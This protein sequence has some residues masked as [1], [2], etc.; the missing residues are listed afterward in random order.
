MCDSSWSKSLLMLVKVTN[1]PTRFF[2]NTFN[3][4]ICRHF[5]FS[6]SLGGVEGDKINDFSLLLLPTRLTN[7]FYFPKNLANKYK[8]KKTIQYCWK[9]IMNIYIK[10]NKKQF[11]KIQDKCEIALM[12]YEEY[13]F[14]LLLL[15]GIRI[16]GCCYPSTGQKKNKKNMRFIFHHWWKNNKKG[17]R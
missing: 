1:T 2:N 9:T 13:F 14:N 4:A 5:Y 15:L 8:K 16:T 11:I 3:F 7:V 12:L 6:T 10:I 17:K